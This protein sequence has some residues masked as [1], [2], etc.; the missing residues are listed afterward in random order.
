MKLM[1]PQYPWSEVRKLNNRWPHKILVWMGLQRSPSTAL[2]LAARD[3]CVR[4]L[5]EFERTRST[6]NFQRPS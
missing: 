2:R 6:Q 5:A 4:M 3:S 1:I